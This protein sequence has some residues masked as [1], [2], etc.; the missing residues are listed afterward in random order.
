MAVYSIYIISIFCQTRT[1]AHY[2][3]LILA[4]VGGWELIHTHTYLYTLFHTYIY[5]NNTQQIMLPLNI[6]NFWLK[7]YHTEMALASL[8][9]NKCA[10]KI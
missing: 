4:P 3:R 8:F 7:T 5:Y 2:A 9:L 1:S 6:C 10:T